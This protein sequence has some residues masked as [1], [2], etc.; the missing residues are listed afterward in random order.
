MPFSNIYMIYLVGS[1]SLLI[2]R[3]AFLKMI[4]GYLQHGF[5]DDSTDQTN[6]FSF[7]FLPFQPGLCDFLSLAHFLCCWETDDFEFLLGFILDSF[8]PRRKVRKNRGRLQI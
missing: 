7:F 4:S 2:N 1:L 3:L 6:F 8:V 5:S